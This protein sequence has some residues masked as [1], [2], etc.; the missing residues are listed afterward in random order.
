MDG[1]TKGRVDLEKVD[2]TAPNYM[3]DVAVPLGAETHGGEDVAVYAGGPGAA[4]FHGVREQNFVYFGMA[5]ALG[6]GE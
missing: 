6:L 3:Q 1:V 2:T 5:G 4:L